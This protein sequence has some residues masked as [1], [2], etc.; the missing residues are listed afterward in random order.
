ML[1]EYKCPSCGTIITKTE[2]YG[3]IVCTNCNFGFITCEVTF[4]SNIT[5]TDSYP[6]W[7]YDPA[8]QV[9]KKSFI[10]NTV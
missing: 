5:D 9:W 2:Q 10:L 8:E 4:S 6:P 1:Y 3:R 7:Y